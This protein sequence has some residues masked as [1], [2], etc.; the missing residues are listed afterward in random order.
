MTPF[1]VAHGLGGRADL[2]VP[3]GYFFVGAGVALVA[4]FIALAFLWQEPRLQEVRYSPGV[5]ARPL[6]AI[7]KVVG[8]L[9]L[10]IVLITGLINGRDNDNQLNALI[11]WIYFWLAV[12]FLSAIFGNMWRHLNPWRTLAS[13]LTEDV[14]ER[15]D[16]LARFGVYPAALA[17]VAFTWLE[18]VPRNR[19]IALTLA[20]AAVFYSAYLFAATRLAGVNSGL[21]MADAFTVYNDLISGQSTVDLAVTGEDRIRRRGWFRALANYPERPG[22]VLFVSAM[23]G[24]V[25][26]D[27]LSESRWWIETFTTVEQEEWFRT[28]GLVALVALVMVAYLSVSAVAARL[29]GAKTM[30][31][32]NRF[33]HTLVP[34]GLAYAVAHYFTLVAFTGQR[35]WHVASDPFGLGWN[36]F[37]TADWTEV[38]WL[39]P[40]AIWYVQVAAIVIGHISGV[41]LAHDRALAD[42]DSEVAVKTQ[43]AMLVLMIGLT[44]LGLWILS[45]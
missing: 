38:I 1:I 17:F 27:G 42:F 32:G 41:V 44:T 43:Y 14:K 39:S 7:L 28:L 20:V 4:S 33:A 19:N 2:P 22:L 18:L 29:A 13:T 45:G 5:R 8:V 21:Q 36:L 11:V 30:R 34:I 9:T 31:V 10:G 16:L 3:I 35:L 37:G 6:S 12:P 25:T 40:N 15:S 23:I 24:T 26:F